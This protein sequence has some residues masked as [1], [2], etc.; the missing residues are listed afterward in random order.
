[1]VHG[2]TSTPITARKQVF[3]GGRY[4]SSQAAADAGP[5][6]APRRGSHTFQTK[7]RIEGCLTWLT[8]NTK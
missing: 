6:P 7:T 2:K 5:K 3:K 1:M 8:T 4:Y